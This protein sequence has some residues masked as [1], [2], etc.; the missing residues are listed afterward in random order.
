MNLCI[1]PLHKVSIFIISLYFFCRPQRSKCNWD[2]HFCSFFYK[3][4]GN[5]VVEI[6]IFNESNVTRCDTLLVDVTP[7]LGWTTYI[8]V[9]LVVSSCFI[10][11]YL[12]CMLIILFSDHVNWSNTVKDNEVNIVSMV[13]PQILLKGTMVIKMPERLTSWKLWM[14][15]YFLKNSLGYCPRHD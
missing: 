10:Y 12:Y 14:I 3:K 11:L 2:L 13:R 8:C 5:K 1:W 9:F 6:V 7:R 15:V 4:S